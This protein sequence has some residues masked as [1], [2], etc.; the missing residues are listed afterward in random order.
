VT[1]HRTTRHNNGHGDHASGG[2][3]QIDAT[4]DTLRVDPRDHF[5]RLDRRVPRRTAAR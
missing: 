2:R 3:T 4:I 1:P 5:D